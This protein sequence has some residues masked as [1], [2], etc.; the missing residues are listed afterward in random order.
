MSTDEIPPE[1]ASAPA[2]GSL[3]ATDVKSYA[4]LAHV[5]TVVGALVYMS[6]LWVP[7]VGLYLYF[8]RKDHAGLLRRHLAEAASLAIVL[9]GYALLVNYALAAADVDDIYFDLLPVV[10]ALVASY[11]CLLAVKAAQRLESYRH[12]KPLAWIPLD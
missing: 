6:L 3:T 9:T 12:P 8:R 1:T 2:P 7:A 11:P 4:T 5:G 10:V